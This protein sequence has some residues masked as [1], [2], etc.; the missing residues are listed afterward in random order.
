MVI[1]SN[2]FTKGGCSL[3]TSGVLYIVF[4]TKIKQD[5]VTQLNYETKKKQK[6]EKRQ[7]RGKL[8]KG[9]SRKEKTR[10]KSNKRKENKRR[11]KHPH[12][13]LGSAWEKT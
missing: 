1:K 8:K 3:G 9:K 6:A 11:E 10:K 4:T 12:I 13:W 7:K 2:R 5:K